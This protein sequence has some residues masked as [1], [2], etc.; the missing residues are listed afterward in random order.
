MAGTRRSLVQEVVGLPPEDALLLNTHDEEFFAAG[1]TRAEAADLGG[2]SDDDDASEHDDQEP[3]ASDDEENL[4]EEH[5]APAEPV[6]TAADTS[7]GKR[8]RRPLQPTTAEEVAARCSQGCGCRSQ[9]CFSLLSQATL[10]QFRNLTER[11]DANQLQVYL[12]GK[13]DALARTG[14]VSHNPSAGEGPPGERRRRTYEYAISGCR[15][16]SAVFLYVHNCS[17]YLLHKIETHLSSGCVGFG[18]HGRTGTAPWNVIP[19]EEVSAVVAFIENYGSRF[20][21][22][23]PAAPRGHNKPA[24]TY[25][26][27]HTTKVLLHGEYVQSGGKLSYVSFTRIWK[28]KCPNIIIMK[29]REDVCATCS[30]LQSKI[31]RARTEEDR[32]ESTRLLQLHMNKAV[33]ARDF[34]RSCIARAKLALHH[35]DPDHVPEYMHLTFDFAQ[36]ATV[37]YHARQVGA[38]YFR[39]PRR[40]QIFG[41]A[42]EAK[43]VQRNYLI[44]ENE[45]IGADGSKA[46][47]PNAV[48]SMLHF[49]LQTYAPASPILGLHADNCCGQNKNKTMLAYLAWR[50]ITGLNTEIQLDFMR[51]GHTRCFVDA[52]FGLLKQ[53][54]RR[55]DVDTLEQLAEV[56]QTSAT[57]NEAEKFG[58][59]WHEWDS[60]FSTHFRPVKNITAYQ[61]F[62]FSAAS[63]GEVAMSISDKHPDKTFRIISQH[64][65]ASNT[66][67]SSALPP[68]LIPA[69][70]SATRAQYLYQHIRQFC[71][72]ESR[73]VTC[74]KPA[75]GDASAAPEVA[76]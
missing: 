61:R 50:I 45:T 67:S 53:R 28:S 27:C 57:M 55:S 3:L 56:V 59:Q 62:T 32:M 14:A 30:M 44:D 40:I 12:A 74:P 43:P 46:H 26:P 42:N 71:H 20:G 38:L 64:H 17:R 1:I 25:L 10:L 70:L 54:Y 33:D 22:P 72:E 5:P 8:K 66:W 29:P 68:V 76:E 51:V 75:G 18:E 37:P 52:G 63:P 35:D 58:W 31:S 73:D 16:C 41:I 65:L 2:D 23:Q 24:P 69:G 7:A 4:D 34:Y 15:I 47:G 13:L 36:Q 48:V 21:L 6:A 60:F 11:M 49:H 9:N 19:D 39:V